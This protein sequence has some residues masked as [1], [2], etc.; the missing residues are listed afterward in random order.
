MIAASD[1]A[2]Q[3]GCLAH[4]VSQYIDKA[5]EAR[6]QRGAKPGFQHDGIVPNTPVA[7]RLDSERMIPA[8]DG[9]I[10]LTALDDARAMIQPFDKHGVI[11]GFQKPE[12]GHVHA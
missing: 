2:V 10:I 5:A 4:A 12:H 3:G 11:A 6:G 9:E 1:A 8:R 7:L